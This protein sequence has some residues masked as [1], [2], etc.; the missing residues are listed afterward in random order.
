[1]KAIIILT[2]LFLG[3]AEAKL[4]SE[5]VGGGDPYAIE[6]VRIGDTINDFLSSSNLFPEIEREDFKTAINNIRNSL[7]DGRNKPLIK[8]QNNEVYCAGT[9]KIGCVFS[10]NT[11]NVNRDGWKNLNPK[12]KIELVSLELLQILNF[13]GRYTLAQSI[14]NYSKEI[15]SPTKNPQKL[16][17]M[18]IALERALKD[19]RRAYPSYLAM[20]P[21]KANY[22]DI[23]KTD[24]VFKNKYEIN[25]QVTT[26]DDYIEDLTYEFKF[27]NKNCIK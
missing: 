22:N 17:C 13:T 23:E 1:M 16:S 25:I 4:G 14:G 24:G 8:F 2:L 11:I 3:K 6:F 9:S 27:L 20:V 18:S 12:E 21:T 10:D 7:D 5:G 15:L 19:A 26:S